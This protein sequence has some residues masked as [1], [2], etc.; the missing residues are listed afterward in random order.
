MKDI[1]ESKI[2]EG[3]FQ[4]FDHTPLH[5]RYFPLEGASDTL[6][7][8]HGHGEHSGRYEKFQDHFLP[9]NMSVA[10]FDCRGQGQ[11]GGEDVYAE[12]FEDFLRDVSAFIDYLENRYGLHR[13]FFILGHS[14]GGLVAVHWAMRNPERVKALVLSSPFLG[15]R[16]PRFLIAFN[17]WMSRVWPHFLY[18]NPVY[19]P[20]LTHNPEEVIQYKKDMLIK[21]KI[22][23]RLLHELIQAMLELDK[24]PA[25]RFPFPFYVLTAESEK[26]VDGSKTKAF[27]E[28]VQAPSKEYISFP[29]FYHEIFNELE[30]AK[31]FDAL[32]GYL[33]RAR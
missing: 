24:I 17:A 28:R 29:G 3:S 10:V 11:S 19:P 5:Y 23:A 2:F 6:V 4:S 8:L 33:R 22:S 12:R 16:L 26:V 1:S 30:Q 13:K 7:I 31:A 27:F 18:Q 25:I 14:M 15:T 20:H 9:E 21:R 32:K